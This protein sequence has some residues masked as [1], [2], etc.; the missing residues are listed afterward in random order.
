VSDEDD[1]E[2]LRLEALNAKRIKTQS[3]LNFLNKVDDTKKNSKHNVY[4]ICYSR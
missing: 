4:Q 3:K 1:L 2:I